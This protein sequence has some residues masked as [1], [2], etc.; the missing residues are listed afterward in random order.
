[1]KVE[2]GRGHN[3]F[4]LLVGGLGY[5][6]AARLFRQRML[7]TPLLFF[8]ATPLHRCVQGDGCAAVRAGAGA[9]GI[10][11]RGAAP[12]GEGATLTRL[13]TEQEILVAIGTNEK[14]VYFGGWLALE[15]VRLGKTTPEQVV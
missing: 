3:P 11:V 4:F 13:V 7:T 6:R 9:G 10:D 1:M 5:L 2:V 15:L 8:A 12:R 14:R